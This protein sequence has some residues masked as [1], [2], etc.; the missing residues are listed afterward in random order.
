M[1]NVMLHTFEL[2]DFEKVVEQVLERKLKSFIPKEKEKLTLLSRK[3]TAKL[4]CI[5][6]PTLHDWTKTGIV[7][8]HRIGN[9]ILYKLEEVNQ[10]LNQIQTS[11]KKGGL[12]C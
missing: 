6:L 12:S 5:S 2:S 3:D 7:K 4:L 1:A 11:T 9:R 10:A 8:A